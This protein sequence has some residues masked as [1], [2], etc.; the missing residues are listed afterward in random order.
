MLREGVDLTILAMGIMTKKALDAAELLAEKGISAEVINVHTIKPLDEET[1]LASVKKTGHVVTAENHNVI[2]GLYSA[3][4]ELLAA[5]APTHVERG[6]GI[7][8]TSDDLEHKFV[9]IEPWS[10]LPEFVSNSRELSEK[11]GIR[12]ICPGGVDRLH[13][14]ITFS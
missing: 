14:F 12:R 5:K 10:S 6:L 9:S 3:V 4:C 8:T 13:Y 11:R 2:G 1:V 7:W